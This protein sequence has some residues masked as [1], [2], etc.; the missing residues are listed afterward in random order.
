MGRLRSYKAAVAGSVQK[1]HSRPRGN[2]VGTNTKMQSF[3]ISP[4]VTKYKFFKGVEYCLFCFIAGTLKQISNIR[5]YKIQL[6]L[7]VNLE[8]DYAHQNHCSF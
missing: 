1:S 8:T 4:Y 6:A 2:L 7:G 3:I 5:L